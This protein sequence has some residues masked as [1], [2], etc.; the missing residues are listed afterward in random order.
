MHV[1]I[2]THPPSISH[3]K[4]AC[5]P[6][7]LTDCPHNHGKNSRRNRHF[8]GLGNLSPFYPSLVIRLT[9]SRALKQ[10]NSCSGSQSHTISSW[11]F[12]IQPKL[13]T[14]MIAS[15]STRSSTRLPF[16]RWISYPCRVCSRLHKRSFLSWVRK[17]ST[18]C[19]SVLVCSIA[20]MA[21]DP[22]DRHG[23]RGM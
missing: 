10:S 21:L 14:S 12:G 13:K 9:Y 19:S 11:E 5:G 20:P 4:T 15:T 22:M 16:S 23:V 8:I 6:T 2:K 7:D 1:A 18:I 17:S 3:L